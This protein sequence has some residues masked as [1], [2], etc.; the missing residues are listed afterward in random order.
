MHY[1]FSE[2][3][4]I[5]CHVWLYYMSFIY[6]QQVQFIQNVIE[7]RYALIN[8]NFL[9]LST[10]TLTEL[11]HILHCSI[12]CFGAASILHMYCKYEVQMQHSMG[13]CTA[14]QHILLWCFKF[15]SLVLQIWST[16]AAHLKIMYCQTAYADY[17]LHLYKKCAA[18]T[19]KVLCLL[20]WK[21][22]ML[23]LCCKWT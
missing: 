16:T 13:L 17:V 22:H 6:H 1:W 18:N 19:Y 20:A 11:Q 21:L 5:N 8:V 15:T 7:F 2:K 23:L 9:N 4:L 14:S 12:C 3:L 10:C